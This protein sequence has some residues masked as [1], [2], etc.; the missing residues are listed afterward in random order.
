MGICITGKTAVYAIIGYPVGHSLSPLMQNDAFL[1]VALDAVYVPFAVHPDHLGNAIDGLRSLAISGFNVT[2]PHKETI[3][4]FLDALDETAKVA[5]AVNTVKRDGEK[6]IGY[7]TDGDGLILSL[8]R[9]FAF[10]PT[11]KKVLIYGAGGAARGAMAALCRKGVSVIYLVNRTKYKADELISDIGKKYGETKFISL[12]TE[13]IFSIPFPEIALLLNTTSLGMKGEKLV[14]LSLDKLPDY[15]IVYD[16]VYGSGLTTP[17]IQEAQ[18]LRLCCA[19]GLGM[20]ACQGELAFEIWTS[21][22][23]DSGT[24][25]NILEQVCTA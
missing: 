15:G 19:N 11:G 10:E 12:S 2:I 18:K 7:N 8:K 14:G 1:R 24:M 16:M 22:K 3:I 25:R 23:P 17:L 5:G 20:L 21:M 13:N 6:L 4:P 9:E